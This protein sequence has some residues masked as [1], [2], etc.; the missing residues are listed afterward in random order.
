MIL[1]ISG[2]TPSL[3]NSKQ[4]F[5]GKNRRPFITASNASKEWRLIAV[6]ELVEQFKGYKVTEY[7]INLTIIFYRST[8]RRFDLDNASSGVLDALV[9]AGVIEDDSFKHINLLH[10]KYGGVDKDN[11][12]AEIHIAE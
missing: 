3:K 4:I 8:M 2:D 1:T 10:L 6:R 9:E 7:P 12:R 5:R 11:P